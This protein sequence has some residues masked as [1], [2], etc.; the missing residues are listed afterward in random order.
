[1]CIVREWDASLIDMI[2][3]S[4]SLLRGKTAMVILKNKTVQDFFHLMIWSTFF[5]NAYYRNICDIISR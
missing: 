2:K 4:V 1:M 5:C 3:V